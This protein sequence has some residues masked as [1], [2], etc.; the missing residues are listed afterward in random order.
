MFSE[1][2][3]FF[4]TLKRILYAFLGVF[5]F[6]LSIKTLRVSTT[7]LGPVLKAFFTSI[8][9][10]PLNSLGF[11]WLS[12]Y[13]ILS[14]SPIAALGLNLLDAEII[15][16]LSAFMIIEGSRLGAAFI[17]VAIGFLE[18][19]RGKSDLL[20]SLSVALLTFIV[21][22]FVFIPGLFVSY[23]LFKSPVIRSL[24]YH[25][26]T[27]ITS[28]ID[29]LFG[30]ISNFFLQTFGAPMTFVI[31]LVILYF[32]LSI[33]DRAFYGIE[34]RE[35]KSSWINYMMRKTYFSFILG[36]LI[37]L[38]AQSVSLS[39]GIIV[40][41]YL[42]G[43]V[44]RRDIIPYIMGANLATFIDTFAVSILLNNPLAMDIVIAV[45]LGNLIVT[46]IALAFYKKFYGVVVDSVNFLLAER[47]ALIIFSL[48]LILV[49]LILF[50]V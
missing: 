13:A 23:F 40:P 6:V 39:L 27:F 20:D 19:L 32:S 18:Y 2:E 42:R 16:S 50:L 10:S 33:F 48:A 36:S 5:I 29:S 8:S 45:V 24:E 4:D 35:A 37:T 26:P 9:N 14:G 47:K 1:L 30:P 22:Y 11:G 49:P 41:L 38:V 34:L 31:S 17:L 28:F 15:S 43:Y 12:S 46:L 25:I 44:Q 21:T 3:E 7:F